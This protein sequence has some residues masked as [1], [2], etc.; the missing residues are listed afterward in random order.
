MK[1]FKYILISILLLSLNDIIISQTATTVSQKIFLVQNTA[2]NGGDF[3]V[4]YQVKG[5]ELTTASTLASL[6]ADITYDSTA[7]RFISGTNWSSGLSS[8]NGYSSHIQSNPTDS[9]SVRWV[10][11]S[12]V[13]PN[14][15]SDGSGTI[16]GMNI[17]GDYVTFVRV[18]FIILDN[19]TSVTISIS[20]RTNQIGLFENPNN[21][22]NSFE[23]T[24]QI[25]DPPVT[26][27]EEPLPVNLASFSATVKS[28]DVKLQWQTSF[29]ENNSGFDVERKNISENEWK[30][31]SF[32]NGK[33][34]KNTPTDYEFTDKKVSSGNYQYRL[35]Q[36]DVNGNYNY[37][38]LNN[39]VNVG[40]PDKFSLSQNYPN[41]FNP[42]TKIDFELPENSI[43]SLIIYDIA[44]REMIRLINNMKYDAGY[45]T[46]EINCKELSSGTYIYRLI[47]DNNGRKYDVSKKMTLIK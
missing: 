44:G 38:E 26:I 4:D 36:I 28:R 12:V 35:K 40:I 15:N 22:P 33:I 17:T 23:I 13:A 16:P 42:S 7:L 37:Y 30:K 45:F 27:N 47:S 14:V 10:R 2:V 21:S 9:G 41:P 11:V 31:L 39:T 43:I 8:E 34:N 6:N 46:K 32:V 19:T 29:E 3:T 24:D 5:N 18:N 20:E 25:L 1:K